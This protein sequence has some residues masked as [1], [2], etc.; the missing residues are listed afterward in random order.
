MEGIDELI[1]GVPRG[2]VLEPLSFNLYLNGLFCLAYITKVCNFA[3]DT[4]L[5]VCDN[6]LNNLINSLNA[7]VAIIQKPVN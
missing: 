4:M 3:D 6:D 1:K 5:H 7:K 2:S